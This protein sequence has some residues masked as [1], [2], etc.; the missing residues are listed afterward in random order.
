MA[1]ESAA[2]WAQAFLDPETGRVGE[3]SQS[4]LVCS[5]GFGAARPAIR[6][7]IFE[8]LLEELAAPD[9]PHLTTGIFGTAFLLEELSR[10]G[11]S[12]VA[13]ALADRSTFPSW[14]WMLENDATTLWERWAGSDDTY[15]H[16][17]PMFGSISGWFFRWLGGIQPA[18][19]AVGF[20]RIVI[21]PQVVPGLEWVKCSHRSI[22]G[23]IESSWFTAPGEWRFE[24]VIP[25]DASALVELPARP[26][27]ELREGG[28]PV[29]EVGD[30]EVLSRGPAT[31]RLQVGSGRYRFTITHEP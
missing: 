7:L 14:G 30:V 3:G 25:P 19:D 6:P 21:R 16:N 9:G 26:G 10:R 4:E 24:V 12:D 22:R 2:A 23:P 17:H 29:S 8:R 5:L 18:E 11:R 20:D 28:R 31:H 1:D 13:M 27:D 15:S